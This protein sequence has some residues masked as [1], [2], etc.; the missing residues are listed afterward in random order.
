MKPYFE[1]ENGKLYHGDCLEI[2]P[3][4]EPLDFIITSPP[5]NMGISSG[6]GISGACDC[7]RW[8]NSNRENG[9][10]LGYDTIDD[11][12]PWDIYEAEQKRFLN[13]C[14]HSLSEKGAIF[15]NHK[16][17][18]WAGEVR[19]PT[20][21]NPGL[22]LRQIIIWDRAGGFNFSASHYVPQHEWILLFA[23]KEFRIA[24]VQ[25]SGKGD[26]WRIPAKPNPL[27]PAPFPLEIAFNILST[28]NIG[29]VC[30]PH[31]GSGTVGL[32]CQKYGWPWIGIEISEKYCEIAAKRIEAE[33]RQLKL[34]A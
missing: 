3:Q 14:W 2:M 4:L 17:R 23:K 31:S 11:A 29:V 18:I 12:K 7:G 32:A 33:T 19:L 28:N 27:H 30:D 9:L 22:P 24:S 8:K 15:Y 1:T 26:V 21:Y 13:L 25:A 34:F 20:I 10:G 5:Y 16:P 6:G